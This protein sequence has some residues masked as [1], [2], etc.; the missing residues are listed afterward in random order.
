MVCPHNVRENERTNH[1][2]T[3][4]SSNKEVEDN[5]PQVTHK[6]GGPQPMDTLPSS[7]IGQTD[8]NILGDTDKNSN[9]TD[10]ITHDGSQDAASSDGDVSK[11]NA[12][13][14]LVNGVASNSESQAA[15]ASVEGRGAAHS[16]NGSGKTGREL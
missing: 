5:V 13:D 7:K 8:P 4:E 15:S 2:Q 10:D 16:D 12:D 1:K 14:V 6:A 3:A 9:A 11:P